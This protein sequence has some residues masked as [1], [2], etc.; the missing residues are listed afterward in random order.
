M[1]K[2]LRMVMS[3]MPRE[4][5][6]DFGSSVVMTE[7]AKARSF[8]AGWSMIRSENRFH[9]SGS[10]TGKENGGG[11]SSAPSERSHRL[12]HAI[13]FLERRVPVRGQG[14]EHFL[15]ACPGCR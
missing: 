12:L 14:V 8:I 10:C 5:A 3:L 9:F 2:R 15:G 13:V 7:V 4:A 11:G 6:R 1:M